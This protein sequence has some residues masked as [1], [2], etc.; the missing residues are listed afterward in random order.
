MEGPVVFWSSSATIG[1]VQKSELELPVFYFIDSHKIIV[2]AEFL[3][4]WEGFAPVVIVLDY[5]IRV[6]PAQEFKRLIL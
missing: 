3:D 6:S 2:V 4:G 5:K 1:S